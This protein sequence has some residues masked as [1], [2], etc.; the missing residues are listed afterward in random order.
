MWLLENTAQS[1]PE[2]ISECF[3]IQQT[4]RA[5]AGHMAFLDLRLEAILLASR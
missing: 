4:R 2:F 1:K 3:T 5:M